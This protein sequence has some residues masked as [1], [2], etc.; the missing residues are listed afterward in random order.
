MLA[1]TSSPFSAAA[2]KVKERLGVSWTRRAWLSL[3]AMVSTRPSRADMETN[4]A[5]R[6]SL[7]KRKRTNE[8]E[9]PLRTRKR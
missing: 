9:R 8:M 1:M 3:T 2:F 4:E 6:A 7:N 5:G